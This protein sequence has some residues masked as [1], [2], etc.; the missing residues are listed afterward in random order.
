MKEL[1]AIAAIIC[2]LILASY[3]S[4]LDFSRTGF[5]GLIGESVFENSASQTMGGMS[6][7]TEEL[8]LMNSL[9]QACFPLFVVSGIDGKH[10]HLRT[11]VSSHFSDGKWS[12]E[13]IRLD[14]PMTFTMGKIYAVKPLV[15]LSGFLPVAKDTV[16]ISI[17][18]KHNSTAG[19][20]YAENVTSP[21]YGVITQ[22]ENFS[23]EKGNY[24][25]AR[26]E[27]SQSEFLRIKELAL[28]ITRNATNDYERA[29]MI[30]EYLKT[31][32]EYS[33]YFNNT[34]MSPYTFLFE[35]KKGI[36]VHFATAF[37]ALATSID[38]PA[39]AVFGYLAKPTSYSQTV[40]SCQAH[41]WA[42]VKFGD[43]WVEFDPTPPSRLKIPTKTE[44][45]KWSKEIVEGEN[46][47][48]KG[49]VSLKDGRSVESGF[50]EIYLKK[51]KTDAEGM[52]LGISRVENGEF[53]LSRKVNKSG[54][55]SIV[56]HYTG[57]LL[58]SDSWSDPE[59]TV[60][61]VPEIKTNLMDFVPE[62][63]HL[64]GRITYRGEGI[65]NKT[66]LVHVDGDR[67]ILKTDENGWFSLNL[68]LSRGTH[69]I[70]I[71]SAK[72]KLFSEVMLSR[73]VQAGEFK[74]MISNTTL[75]AGEEN[76][77]VVRVLFNDQPYNGRI[78]I[79]GS[80]YEVK[81]GTLMLKFMVNKLG[82]IVMDVRIGGYTERLF[83]LSKAKTRISVEENGDEIVFTVVSDY[84]ITP[85]G[86]I[87][88]NGN[89]YQLQK[90]SVRIEKNGDRFRVRYLG[91]DFNLPSSTEYK[92]TNPL[93]YLIPLP[94]IG[95]IAAYLYTTYPR[96]RFEFVKEYPDL[97][98][99][100]K[101]GEVVR[102]NL[103]AN[104]PCTV[105]VDGEIAAD[106]FIKLDNAGMYR[107]IIRALKNGKVRKEVVRHIE[108]VD[109]YGKGV[110]RVFRMFESELE[111][112]GV[113]TSNLTAREVMNL[114]GESGERREKLLRL[115][116]LYEY[117][118]KGGYGRREFI[119]AF[120]I[121][122][123]LRRVL[124]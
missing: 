70:E 4:T 116:E 85:S 114:V 112:R 20:F 72:E 115:F 121:Y 52:L 32:Y 60:L 105:E 80:M 11:F 45:T 92:I 88:I 35:E 22:P 38:L 57:S 28:E 67:Y 104:Y 43:Y 33:P 13:K 106:G 15:K 65:P 7:S 24:K 53:S 120:E 37:I 19:L 26:I 50:V 34:R 44:I 56:A 31:H 79:N 73:V 25:K 55:Y 93:I 18:A 2:L 86:K 113:R 78:E 9:D 41:M 14:D 81:N 89:R 98:N 48:V 91:D 63:F 54:E 68:T 118:G 83:L 100:W 69:R 62:N 10:V 102:Y 90:G 30:E 74:I 124:K 36:C 16:S 87:E 111:K 46:I 109:D 23:L 96:I 29:K 39:R 64:K 8:S 119:E 110:E 47:S 99:L 49:R 76:R 66:V 123:D 82:R 84:N 21:Y 12:M 107:I 108:I 59:V 95:G 122:S 103:T 71:I 17:S 6:E 101:A 42:E 117:A 94:F 3:L 77:V 5:P 27:M 61:S 1:P 51:N 40:Y 75:I 97:P 58:Y